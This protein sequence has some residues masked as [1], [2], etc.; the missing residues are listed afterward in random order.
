MESLNLPVTT[1]CEVFL[2]WLERADL[3]AVGI[4]KGYRGFRVSGI[5]ATGLCCTSA[6]VRVERGL[7]KGLGSILQGEAFLFAIEKK[8]GSPVVPFPALDWVLGS[9]KRS[10]P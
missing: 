1:P 7:K 9:L 3:Q 5:W 6:V 10:Q 2:G 4:H 8:L